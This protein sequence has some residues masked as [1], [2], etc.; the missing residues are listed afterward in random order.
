MPNKRGKNNCCGCY[1]DHFAELSIQQR[2]FLSEESLNEDGPHFGIS[3]EDGKIGA[4]QAT[5][6]VCAH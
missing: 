5:V 3:R 1:L 6:L 4:Y 2:I